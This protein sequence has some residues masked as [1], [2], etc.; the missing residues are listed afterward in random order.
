MLHGKKNLRMTW[1]W[2][3]TGIADCGRKSPPSCTEPLI[4]D[5]AT[6]IIL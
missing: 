2:A 3:H 6:V 4:S 5:P 1:Q